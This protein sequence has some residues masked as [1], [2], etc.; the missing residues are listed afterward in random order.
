[1][2][3]VRAADCVVIVTNHSQYD[4]PAILQAASLIFDTRNALGQLGKGNPKVV[5]L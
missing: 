4:Y 1:M 2:A 5:R 3:A